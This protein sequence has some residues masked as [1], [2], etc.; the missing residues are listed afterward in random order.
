MTRSITFLIAAAILAPLYLLPN[1]MA[2]EKRMGEWFG[3][4][5]ATSPS[6]CEFEVPAIGKL[7]KDG[8]LTTRF[9]H[10]GTNWLVEFDQNGHGKM[11]GRIEFEYES[12]Q[13][14]RPYEGW[15]QISGKFSGSLFEGNFSATP[16][17]SALVFCWG[18]IVLVRQGT[19]AAKAL[20][21]GSELKELRIIAVTDD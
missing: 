8:R 5:R 14:K 7:S 2:A 18:K 11:P 3:F 15:M 12:V 20:H 4:L 9:I 6:D 21:A 16:L 1:A 19:R 17:T 13:Q 10:L